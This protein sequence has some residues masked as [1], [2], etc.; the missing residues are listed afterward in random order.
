MSLSINNTT[1]PQDIFVK[2]K[3]TVYR[4]YIFNEAE[5]KRPIHVPLPLS[6]SNEF[7]YVH[8]VTCMGP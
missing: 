4:T 2:E 6:S 7:G 3:A 8:L 5:I 1:S